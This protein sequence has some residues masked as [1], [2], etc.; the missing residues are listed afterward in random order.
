MFNCPKKPMFKAPTGS[1]GPAKD[2]SSSLLAFS[3]ASVE[4]NYKVS[5]LLRSDW[6]GLSNIS[7]AEGRAG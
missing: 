6:C 3:S 2:T 7:P 1:S 4:E 5:L